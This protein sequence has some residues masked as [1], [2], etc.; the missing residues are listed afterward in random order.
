MR[1]A[2]I[3]HR[4]FLKKLRIFGEGVWGRRSPPQGYV[5]KCVRV[6]PCVHGGG[7][8]EPEPPPGTHGKMRARSSVLHE[9]DL[10][11]RPPQGHSPNDM[12]IC[13]C[14]LPYWGVFRGPLGVLGSC[15]GPEGSGGVLGGLGGSQGGSGGVLGGPWKWSFSLFLEVNLSMVLA[16]IDVFS[17]E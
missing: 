10:G 12:V 7:L 5:V 9:G 4:A 8:G 1:C 11:G 16:N 14:D 17:F 2:Q 6:L 15:G 13:V 3:R